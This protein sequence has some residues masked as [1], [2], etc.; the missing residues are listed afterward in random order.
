MGENDRKEE[1]KDKLLCKRDIEF[2]IVTL[3]GSIGLIF[4]VAWLVRL[5]EGT[6]KLDVWLSYYGSICG[7]MFGGWITAVGLYITFKVNAKQ[8]KEQREHDDEKFNQQM[9]IQII[10][11]KIN[12]YTLCVESLIKLK[13][14]A[15]DL[16]KYVKDYK[17]TVGDEIF[18]ASM[19]RYSREE[20]ENE[21]NG[22]KIH[23]LSIMYDKYEEYN[24]SYDI[25]SI[26]C[27]GISEKEKNKSLKTTINTID[28]IIGDTIYSIKK[29]NNLECYKYV[30]YFGKGSK[31]T[32]E[33]CNIF[34][35]VREVIF[36]YDTL[37][38]DIDN[39]IATCKS[40][41][42]DEIK[43]LYQEKYLFNNEQKLSNNI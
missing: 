22:V 12:D 39:Y 21:R 19:G 15:K 37:N 5:H 13:E 29:F 41:V 24:L 14:S 23:D 10:N 18:E 16:Y 28:G 17:E 32:D 9:K 3:L 6:I 27:F 26:R 33:L 34:Y 11:E 42:K 4:L 1:K 43:L 20:S 2:I 40:I 8:L 36:Q 30:H 7:A 31:T 35:G 25:T 38:I